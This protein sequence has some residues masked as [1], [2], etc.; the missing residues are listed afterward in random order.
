MRMTAAVA[1]VASRLR[2]A[3]IEASRWEARLLIGQAADAGQEA[4][5]GFPERTL[6]AAQLQALE[7]LVTRRLR[8]EPVSRI[9]G[10]R[11]FWSLRFRL[12]PATFDPRPDSE[13]VVLTALDLVGNRAAELRVLDLGVGTGCLLLSLLH[14]LPR[15]GG[16]GVDRNAG[17]LAVAAA[18]AKALGVADRAVFALGDWGE[19]IRGPFDLIVCNP[20]YVPSSSIDELSP[21]VLG[22]DPRL[23]LDGGADGLDCY[24][25]LAPDVARLL[26]ARGCAVIEV[27][28]GQVDAVAVILMAAGLSPASRVLDLA[29]VARCVVVRGPAPTKSD[30]REG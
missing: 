11:E 3:G 9:R 19:D 14:E 28:L 18:N 13:T 24:R 15:A 26:G 10:W 4:V 30:R 25:A 2:Q 20:P 23:A 29:G 7:H 1:D 12:T 16:V 5:I 17:V 6:S 22:Y 27:G 21:E 8:R